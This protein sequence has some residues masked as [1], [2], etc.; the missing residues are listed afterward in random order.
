F[1]ITLVT[2]VLAACATSPAGPSKLPP[3]PPTE[4]RPSAETLHRVDVADPYHWLEDQTSS[5]TRAWIDRQNAY[6]D[7]VLEHRKE[8]TMFAS[9]LTQLMSTDQVEA[10]LYR[11][12]RYFF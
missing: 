7:Q 4:V 12:G 3:P 10:P 11:S 8:A 6:T 9:R 2:L 5:E 1:S